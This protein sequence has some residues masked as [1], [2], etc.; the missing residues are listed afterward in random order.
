M[1]HY[2]LVLLA[3]NERDNLFVIKATKLI[4]SGINLI[5]MSLLVFQFSV[6]KILNVVVWCET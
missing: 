3:I 1:S 4:N 2:K 5:G 6:N